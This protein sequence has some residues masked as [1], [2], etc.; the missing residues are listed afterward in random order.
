MAVEVETRSI[1]AADGRELCVETAGVVSGRPVLVHNGTPNSRHLYG[2]W[3]ADANRRGIWLISYDRPGYGGST[4]DPGHT[5]ADGAADVR[6]ITEA[7]GIDRLAIWGL[8]GGGPYALAC[9]ALLP[10]LVVA[11]ATVGSVAPYGAPGLDYFSGMGEGNVDSINL[12]L[13]D[14]DAARKKGKE[15]R[16]EMLQ[17]SPVQVAEVLQTLL[18]PVDAAV[19]TGDFAQWLVRSTHEGLRQ[20]DQGWWDDGVAHMSAWGFDLASIRVPVKVWHGRHDRFVPFQ[21]GEWLSQHVSG[22]T[23]ELS[24]EQGHLTLLVAKVPDVHEW[25]LGNF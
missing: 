19:L 17:A 22:A 18:S 14:P 6:A 5:V 11:A 21:H 4:P 10:G 20:G 13:S 1:R 25:L 3:V 7:L 12:Y 23:A 2:P 15:D 24:E 9:A 16:D 8:S